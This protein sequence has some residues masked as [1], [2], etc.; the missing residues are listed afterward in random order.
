MKPYIIMRAY[1]DEIIGED[2]LEKLVD[3]GFA[4]C[5]YRPS[6]HNIDPTVVSCYRA[7]A[8]ST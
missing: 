1:R 6:F 8:R 7:Y 4:G 2:A 3:D 5:S